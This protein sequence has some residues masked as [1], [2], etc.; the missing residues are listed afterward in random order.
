MKI[1]LCAIVKDDTELDSLKIMVDSASNY[2]DSVHITANGDTVTEIKAYC[3]GEG[4]DFSFLKWNDDFSEQR[5]YNFSKAPKDTDFIFW[6]DADDYLWNGSHLREIARIIK[7][8]DKDVLYMTYWY[9][10]LFKGDPSPETLVD[11]ELFHMRERLIKPGTITWKKRI[12]ESPVPPE[13]AKYRHS[14]YSYDDKKRPM[15]ILHL[16]ADR[17]LTAESLVKRM[18]RNKRILEL[19]L[20]EEWDRNEPDPRTILYLMKIY[21]ESE[22]PDLWNKCIQMGGDYISM[23]GWDEERNT[24][25][26]LMAKCY[27]KMNNNEKALEFLYM[28]L[29]EYPTEVST[30]LKLSEACYNIK[31]YREMKH[32]LDVAL[33]M[34]T[35][36]TTAG[37]QNILELKVLS[38]ELVLKYHFNVDRNIRKAAE[39]AENL[40]SLTPTKNNKENWDYLLDLSDLD[41][42]CENTDKLVQYLDSI[43]E[44]KSVLALLDSLPQSIASQLFAIKLHQRYS[45]P[46]KWEKDEICYF[47]NFGSKHFEEWSGRSLSKGIGGSET[48]VI[49]LSRQWVK[50]GYKVTVYG[51]PG[52]DKGVIDGVN[53]L[54]WYMFNT[55][56]SFNI[57]IQWRNSALAGKVKCK[58]FY[59]DLHD[60]WHPIDYMKILPRI[61]KIMVKSKYQ[62]SLAPNIP[63]DKFIIA[64]NG[65]SK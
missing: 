40:Y 37:M 20:Q 32:W 34:D 53:Y 39:A 1:A 23:S 3:E 51:D 55:K 33:K 16:G 30:Y 8:T 45:K 64:S 62:R 21:A 49:E 6:M 13:G 4:Y 24:C 63:D 41:K 61:D 42:A 50:M 12:H 57:I 15:A 36:K 19:E 2:V 18:E 38:S 65:I 54:P 56:D 58:K 48:A 46:K 25:Y 44:E 52:A 29:R 47:A 28:G 17:N 9:G 7:N 22:E 10:C 27:G 26:Q 31:K 14:T 11:V 35:E 60:I 59:V 43:N 5:N